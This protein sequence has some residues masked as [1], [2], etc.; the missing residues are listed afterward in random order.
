MLKGYTSVKTVMAK[1]YRDLNLTVD[2]PESSVVEW[3][4]EILEK[5]GTF[6]QYDNLKECIDIVDGKAKLPTNFHKL[7]DIAYQSKP[8][9]WA[10]NTMYN[11]YACDNCT[12]PSCCG[13]YEFY[14]NN[15]YIITNITD[16]NEQL[17][18]IYL[19]V[20]TDEEGYPLVPDDA[21]FMD[22]CTS[23]V[24]YKLDY[25]EWRKGNLPDKVFQKSEQEY[26]FYVRAAKASANMPNAAQLEN[27]KNVWVRLIPK[28]DQYSSFFKDI[29]KPERRKLH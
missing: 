26:L 28:Q 16:T 18:V 7:V 22:A 8:L 27:L 6:A 3:I 23:Y 12:I 19:G 29:N 9:N 25:Q 21:Y 1:L 2:I 13:D 10:T 15:N 14:I 5:I 20:P 4:A 24:T 17:C 11:D